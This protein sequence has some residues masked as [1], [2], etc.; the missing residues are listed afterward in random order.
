MVPF[1]CKSGRMT[2]FNKKCVECF[3]PLEEGI[4]C[5]KCQET[6]SDPP[7]HIEDETE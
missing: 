3:Q 1:I 7:W 5:D 6:L 4:I 2:I